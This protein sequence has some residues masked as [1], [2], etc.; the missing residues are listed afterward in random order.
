MCVPAFAQKSSVP[1]RS[2][3][4]RRESPLRGELPSQGNH[5]FDSEPQEGYADTGESELDPGVQGPGLE[6]QYDAGVG[7]FTRPLE[8]GHQH[9]HGAIA[10]VRLVRHGFVV[11]LPGAAGV[12]GPCVVLLQSAGHVVLGVFALEF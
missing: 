12:H 8:P 10:E 7:G 5:S 2:S 9:I 3:E 6:E 11:A 4:E 1:G